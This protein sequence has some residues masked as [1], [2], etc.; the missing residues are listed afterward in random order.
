MVHIGCCLAKYA[1][2]YFSSTK[3]Y[4]ADRVKFYPYLFLLFC[5]PNGVCIFLNIAIIL[6]SY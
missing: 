2:I 6:A 3:I 1:D 5:K 4:S